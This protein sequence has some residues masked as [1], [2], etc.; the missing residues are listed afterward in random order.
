MPLRC[1]SA[2][3]ETRTRATLVE[4]LPSSTQDAGS[5]PAASTSSDADGTRGLVRVSS[6]CPQSEYSVKPSPVGWL[7]SLG[8]PVG[9]VAETVLAGLV[10]RLFAG[11]VGTKRA[12]TQAAQGLQGITAPNVG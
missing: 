10:G 4:A 6:F 8:K 9:V 5:I 7:L 1:G 2:G 3:G 11:C 12:Q